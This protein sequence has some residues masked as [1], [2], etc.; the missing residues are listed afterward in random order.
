M[1]FLLENVFPLLMLLWAVFSRIDKHKKEK[2]KKQKREKLI[3]KKKG[4]FMETVSSL[5]EEWRIPQRQKVSKIPKGQSAKKQQNIKEPKKIARSARSEFDLI[6][7]EHIS[8]EGFSANSD[9]VERQHSLPQEKTVSKAGFVDKESSVDKEQRKITAIDW[10]QAI[11]LKEI[12]DKPVSLR[13]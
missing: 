11:V 3:Q 12:L 9:Y 6:P 5:E 1:D 13:K 2:L 10:K 8:E 4:A 7:D